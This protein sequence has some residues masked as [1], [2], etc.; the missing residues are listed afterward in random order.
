MPEW[1]RCIFAERA[2]GIF[3]VEDNLERSRNARL[4]AT[5]AGLI[6][7][8]IGEAIEVN[9]ASLRASAD[10]RSTSL[11]AVDGKS[12]GG[13]DAGHSCDPAVRLPCRNALQAPPEIRGD[14]ISC[15]SFAPHWHHGDSKVAGANFDQSVLLGR[16]LHGLLLGS[17]YFERRATR[18]PLSSPLVLCHSTGLEFSWMSGDESAWDETSPCCPLNASLWSAARIDGCATRSI[19]RFFCCYCGDFILLLPAEP[20]PLL[21]GG[22]LVLCQ[23]PGRRGVPAE[24]PDIRLI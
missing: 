9:E 5:T 23:D 7:P 13:Q 8:P 4:R 22:F 19:P 6:S 1:Q 12:L 3:V 16:G 24:D 11:P 10:C 21:V 2:V 14:H 18:T 15:P 17:S 20:F